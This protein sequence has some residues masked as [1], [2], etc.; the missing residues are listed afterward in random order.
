MDGDLARDVRGLRAWRH[1]HADPCL[2][3]HGWRLDALD[4]WRK[5]FTREV[6]RR[7]DGCESE[8]DAMTRAEE[9][10]QAVAEQVR[11]DV[12]LVWTP[13]RKIGAGSF[14]LA[15]VILPVLV[16]RLLS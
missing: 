3:A 12:A 9:I 5:E 16:E 13:W 11:R 1:D 2:L 10:A 4:D 15:L 8:I 7:L 6:L 14:A